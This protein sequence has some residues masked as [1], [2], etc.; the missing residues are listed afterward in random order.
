VSVLFTRIGDTLKNGGREDSAKKVYEMVM[1]TYPDSDGHAISAIRM[2][3]LFTKPSEKEAQYRTVMQS[4][5]G[6]P[7]A[8][9]AVIRLADLQQQAGSY[10]AGIETL[11]D[12]MSEGLKELKNEAEYVMGSCFDGYFRQLTEGEDP[13][14]VIAAYEKDRT[15]VNRLENPDIFEA[16][17]AAF[18]EV[19]LFQQAEEL[20]QKS[21]KESTSRNRP[22][23]LYYLLAVTLQELG[24]NMQ[25]KEMLHAYFRK[26][27]ESKHNIDAYLR[28]GRLLAADESRETALAFIKSGLKKS[29]TNMQKAEFLL[30]QAQVHGEMGQDATV[31]DLLIKAINL[32]ASSPEAENK[33]LV[34][35]YRRL[36]ESHIK[37]SAFDKAAD[38]YTM[39][40]NFS[41]DGR[42]PSLLYLLA[43]ANLKSQQTE[44]ARMVFTEILG[45]GDDFWARMAEEQLRTMAI[46][47]KLEAQG[48]P[49]TGSATGENGQ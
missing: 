3:D 13:L 21:Y 23:S 27:P 8:K 20:L 43:E 10:S 18:Y 39:A 17:G 44:A 7:M 28:M 45:S 14:A 40:L 22:A 36:G 38:A 30:L 15:L 42:P 24:K 46:E 5:P 37:L 2:A 25:A 6:H 47:E 35:A 34:K 9:L 32:L 48:G 49:T 31:P 12:V 41:E 26:L 16:V 1:E 29:E 11:R 19:K 4:F 33:H